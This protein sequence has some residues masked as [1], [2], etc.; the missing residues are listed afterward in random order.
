MSDQ[1]NELQHTRR[2][3]SY[4][5]THAGKKDGVLKA[6]EEGKIVIPDDGHPGQLSSRAV[7]HRAWMRA[8][9][10]TYEIEYEEVLEPLGHRA[11]HPCLFLEA[12]CSW[13]LLL[14]GNG[15]ST[16]AYHAGAS[17]CVQGCNLFMLTMHALPLYVSVPAC[18]AAI[19]S[20]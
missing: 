10:N 17:A 13:P 11:K 16:I 9:T 3:F 18:K 19:F 15:C 20:C 1:S 14:V 4:A 8:E 12:A 6:W 5:A 7:D 2:R